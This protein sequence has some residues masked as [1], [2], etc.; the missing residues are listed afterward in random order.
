MKLVDKYQLYIIDLDGVLYIGNQ[1]ISGVKETIN[2]LLQ[3]GKKLKYLTNDPRE[4]SS[5]YAQ[6]L[7]DMGIPV[8]SKDII[9]SSMAIARHI[10]NEHADLRGEKAYVI[11]SNALKEEIS[12]TGLVLVDKEDAK[13]ADFVIVGG[14]PDFHYEEIKLS[15]IAIRNGAYFYATNRDAVV[16][17]PE[18][19]IPATG[20]L[21][22]SIETA[23]GK[24]A[25]VAGKPEIIMFEVALKNSDN[26]IKKGAVIIGDGL[27]TDILGGKKA[28]ISTILVLSGSTDIEDLN[29]INIEPDYILNNIN[30]LLIKEI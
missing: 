22:A 10:E 18:G 16:P 13:K 3:K 29:K 1:P 14:H 28:G 12:L 17:S 23:S 6:K 15:T 26:N 27:E 7:S 9:T 8:C 5:N 24:K 30:E 19:H 2:T 25:K 11:G 20:A 4:S 21:L